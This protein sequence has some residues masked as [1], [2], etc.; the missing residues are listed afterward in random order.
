M[1]GRAGES[2]KIVAYS[3]TVEPLYNGHLRAEFSG[4][5]KEVA[6]MG[7]FSIREFE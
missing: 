2:E 1:E 5:C 6:S 7:R 4:H 3:N